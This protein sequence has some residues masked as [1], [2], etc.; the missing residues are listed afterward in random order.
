MAYDVLVEQVPTRAVQEYLAIVE[1]AAVDGE[2]L[3]DN[4]L[5]CLLDGEER[6]TALAVT[7]F[8]RCQT[9]VPEITAVVVATVNLSCFDDLLTEKEAW[10]D[11][12]QGSEK[13]VAGPTAVAAFA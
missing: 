7:Q 2:V 9:L 5:G 4:A 8:V 11:S 10:S 1:L 6:L 13:H 12:S 3:V